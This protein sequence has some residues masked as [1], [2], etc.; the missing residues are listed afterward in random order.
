M[1]IL[2][3]L[4]VLFEFEVALDQHKNLKVNFEFGHFQKRNNIFYY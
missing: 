4:S 1:S 3:Y 2:G